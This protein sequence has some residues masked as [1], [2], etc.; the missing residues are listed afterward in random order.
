MSITH[1][2]NC[3]CDEC[4]ANIESG[5]DVYCK[6]C[7][8]KMADSIAVAENDVDVHEITIADL[9]REIEKLRSRLREVEPRNT[10]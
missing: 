9:E 7:F 2:F 1:E 4:G 8:Q 6:R 3:E 10:G 5:D